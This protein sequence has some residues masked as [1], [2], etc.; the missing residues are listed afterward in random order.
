MQLVANEHSLPRTVDKV[1]HK[2]FDQRQTAQLSS[3][4]KLSWV[5]D[6]G[7]DPQ[8]SCGRV[9]MCMLAMCLPAVLPHLPELWGEDMLMTRP[10]M[11]GLLA[12]RL[13]IYACLQFGILIIHK[14]IRLPRHPGSSLLLHNTMQ[15]SLPNRQQGPVQA[16]AQPTGLASRHPAPL[17]G[18]LRCPPASEP[19]HALSPSIRAQQ[20]KSE[21]GGCRFY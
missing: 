7:R 13:L 19:R 11:Q 15:A 14:T 6:L 3:D 12:C 16:H 10:P 5:S 1:P 17:A 9:F 18:T 4:H 20:G 2:T 21:N 8:P